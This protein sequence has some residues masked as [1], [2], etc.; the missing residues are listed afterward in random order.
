MDD[1]RREAADEAI[2]G[3]D[4]DSDA[5]VGEMDGWE[6]TAPGDEWTRR[7]YIESDPQD[8]DEDS[9][10]VTF[11]VRFAPSEPRVV[12]A[13]AIDDGGNIFGSAATAG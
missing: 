9:T 10:A 4:F 8:I 1:A 5:V 6:R 13:Y 12:E 2:D 11:T 3:Y 7:V